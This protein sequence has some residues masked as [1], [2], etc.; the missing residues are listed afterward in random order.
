M[1]TYWYDAYINTYL[2]KNKS[3]RLENMRLTWFQEF[4][5]QKAFKGTSVRKRKLT[6]IGNLYLKDLGPDTLAKI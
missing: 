5:L 3:P 6:E 1:Y 4:A 2:N